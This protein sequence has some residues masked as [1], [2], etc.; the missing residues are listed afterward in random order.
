MDFRHCHSRFAGA[1]TASKSP[2][3]WQTFFIARWGSSDLVT[4]YWSRAEWF[5]A[6]GYEPARGIGCLWSTI[7]ARFWHLAND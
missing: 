2:H 6:S 5:M 4:C 1:L 3:S 7:D